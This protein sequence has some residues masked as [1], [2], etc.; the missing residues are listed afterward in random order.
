MRVTKSFIAPTGP[1]SLVNITEEKRSGLSSIFGVEFSL[2]RHL[3]EVKYSGEH[4]SGS[5]GPLVSDL[6]QG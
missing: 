2:C 6:K 1:L 5:C 4:S 3:N